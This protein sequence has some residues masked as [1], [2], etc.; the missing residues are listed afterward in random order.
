[1]GTSREDDPA[2]PPPF[3]RVDW[4]SV[5]GGFEPSPQS[6]ALAVAAALL[7][8][9]FAFDIFVRAGQETFGFWDVSRMDWLT[10]ATA[11]VVV[12][13]VGVPA[14][15]EPDRVIRFLERYPR[16]PLSLGSLA[17]VVLVGLVGAVGPLALAQ[18]ELD[19]T[20]AGQ[21][22]AF[23]SVATK[24]LT[25]CV[26]PEVGERCYGTLD[27]PLGTTRGG[28]SVLV[29]LVY[30]ARTAVQ[31][32]L[33]VTAISTPLAVLVG[34]ATAYYG[35][36]VDAVLTR[37][38]EFQEAIP[39]FIVYFLLVLFVGPT[40]FVLV[41]VYGLFNWAGMALGIRQAARSEKQRPY[42]R[43]ARSAGASP[44]AV[45]RHHLIPNTSETLVTHVTLLVPKLI[46][47]EA[48]F[49]FIGLSGD[50]SFSWGQLIQ[51]GL[52]WQGPSQLE[53]LWWIGTLPAVAILLTVVAL[54]VVGDGI[55]AAFEP[56]ERR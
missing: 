25:T 41:A 4:S 45:V 32:A 2:E 8:G 7:A 38:L 20:R 13:Y 11:A 9:L 22:P 14:A 37:L 1:M 55:Q 27:A 28:E 23:T 52:K 42:V 34:T 18:P 29:W 44:V 19:L 24:F 48:L 53:G 56:R 51:R 21:P 26:G 12:S 33:V 3:Q 6:L 50:Q 30:G 47:I 10:L 5:E 16:D 36:R 35:G 15:S 46:L 43:A 39:T 40:L 49:S 17:F 54:N 31:F